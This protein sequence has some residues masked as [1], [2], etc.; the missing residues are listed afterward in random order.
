MSEWTLAAVPPGAELRRA[1]GVALEALAGGQTLLLRD[2]L[3]EGSRIDFLT[4]DAAGRV[5]VV[6]LAQAGDDLA[7]V[8]RGLAQRAWVE[9]RLPDWA[10]LAPGRGLQD[11][12]ELRALLVCPHFGAESRAAARAAGTDLLELAQCRMLAKGRESSLVLELID[13][14][15]A[16]LPDRVSPGPELPQSSKPQTPP[17]RSG[18]REEDLRLTPQEIR[19]FE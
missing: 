4:R 8:A 13:D 9:A 3:G 5:R 18:L 6:L 2:A 11:A 1:L 10:Q 19:E 12:A 15:P 7:L 16:E 14:D 17:F